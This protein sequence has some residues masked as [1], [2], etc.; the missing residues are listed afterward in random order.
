M[1]TA[2]LL[3][4]EKF[5]QELPFEEVDVPEQR[6]PLDAPVAEE[7]GIAV[8]LGERAQY[9][10]KSLNTVEEAYKLAGYIKGINARRKGVVTKA[11]PQVALRGAHERTAHLMRTAKE[12]FAHGAGYTALRNADGTLPQEAQDELDL[13]FVSFKSKY[14]GPKKED[15][16]KEFKTKLQKAALSD[17]K[18][19]K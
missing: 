7:P 16:R 12:Q 8:D 14:A 11:N 9:L 1:S 4:P 2:P 15:A 17:T 3:L 5:E 18:S 13:A 6:V 19:V 10:I